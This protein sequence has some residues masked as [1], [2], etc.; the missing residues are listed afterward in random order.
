MIY[1]FHFCFFVFQLSTGKTFEVFVRFDTELEMTYYMHKGILN[2]M[3]R[4]MVWYKYKL[5]TLEIYTAN[6]NHQYLCDCYYFFVFN[7]NPFFIETEKLKWIIK[8][9]MTLS[10]IIGYCFIS[11]SPRVEMANKIVC[12]TYILLLRLPPLPL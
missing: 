5:E 4:N 11:K 3:V 6:I 7:F 1:W 8:I 10:S 2:M 12:S 9:L